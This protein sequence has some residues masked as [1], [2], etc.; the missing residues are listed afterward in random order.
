M[1]RSNAIARTHRL[2]ASSLG[3]LFE[4]R[5]PTK[6]AGLRLSSLAYRCIIQVPFY[7]AWSCSTKLR[8]FG[9]A[10]PTE[11]PTRTPPYGNQPL[12]RRSGFTGP[13]N[14]DVTMAFGLPNMTITTAAYGQAVVQPYVGPTVFMDD[15]YMIPPSIPADGLSVESAG[16]AGP[17]KD[18]GQRSRRRTS[19]SSESMA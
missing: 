13:A 12:L 6:L 9:W 8:V 19:E 17:G 16:G 4:G 5:S 18:G 1:K 7:P 2:I 15:K 10:E 14:I 3:G 11:P